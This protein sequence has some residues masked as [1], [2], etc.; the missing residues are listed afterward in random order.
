MGLYSY[1]RYRDQ[2]ICVYCE[3]EIGQE[4]DHVL[5]RSR[6]GKTISA[7]LVLACGACNRAKYSHLD[8]EMIRKAF[9]HLSKHGESLDWVY[10]ISV[11]SDTE[12]F[13]SVLAAIKEED[14]KDEERD[15]QDE[16]DWIQRNQEDEARH[17]R[18]LD[19]QKKFQTREKS[20]E[21]LQKM[22]DRE[23]KKIVRLQEELAK[24]I[25]NT[26]KLK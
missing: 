17:H 10:E 11:N 20:V 18:S 2:G 7:N 16:L 24:N 5:P 9:V 4:I 22:L 25:S 26:K 6:G 13:R 1:I 15:R 21:E 8:E 23:H 14:H 3:D 19:L 12:S